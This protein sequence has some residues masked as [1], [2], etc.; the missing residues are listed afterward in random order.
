VS[1]DDGDEDALDEG[2]TELLGVPVTDPLID[3]DGD[4]LIEEDA[5]GLGVIEAL[6]VPRC[7]LEPVVEGVPITLPQ[8]VAT[9]QQVCLM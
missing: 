3:C 1:L 6:L 4:E 9:S 8:R 5:D 7:E 2:D